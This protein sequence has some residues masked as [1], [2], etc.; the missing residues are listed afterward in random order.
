MLPYRV[1]DMGEQTARTSPEG[2]LEC[3]WVRFYPQDANGRPPTTRGGLTAQAHE[4]DRVRGLAS[5]F[6]VQFQKPVKRRLAAAVAPVAEFSSTHPL[7]SRF[8]PARGAGLT[9]L[10]RPHLVQTAFTIGVA[11]T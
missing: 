4:T 8:G 7:D 2:L 3:G 6:D 10:V 1:S 9:T 11:V 5:G